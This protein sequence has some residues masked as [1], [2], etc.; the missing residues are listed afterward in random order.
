MAKRSRAVGSPPA[1]VVMIH[2]IRTYGQWQKTLGDALAAV[3]YPHLTHDYG[4]FGLHR[5]AWPAARSNRVEAFYDWYGEKRDLHLAKNKGPFRPNIVAHSMGTY[6]V[7]RAMEKFSDMHFGKIV[8]CGAILPRN[9]NWPL[10]IARDQVDEVLNDYGVDDIWA[11]FARLLARDAGSSGAKGF[12]L[13]RP[14]VRQRRFEKFRHSDYFRKSHYDQWIGYFQEKGLPLRTL[15]TSNLPSH[16]TWK[17]LSTQTRAIDR[18]VYEELD[19][20]SDV[21]LP[22]GLSAKWL[23]VNPDIYTLLVDLSE[24]VR[25]YVN[26]M[27]LKPEAFRLAME[28]KL[29]EAHIQP[30]HV[31]PYSDDMEVDIYLMSIAVDPDFRLAN[32]G[33]DQPA[34]HKLWYGL[35]EHLGALAQ[36]RRIF[37]RSMGAIVWSTE[38][39]TLCDQLGMREVAKDRFG[40]PIVR[41]DFKGP[42]APRKPTRLVRDLFRKYAQLGWP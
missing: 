31:Q 35:S 33:P 37:V 19:H 28:D 23:A 30:E 32:Q 29:R 21:A 11:R 41:L 34:F 6:I 15:R 1:A 8:F 17:E 13:G 18:R 40:H 2:G 3:P 5:F 38:G 12:T 36:E 22:K 25:G 14:L 16:L 26:A 20:Y 24:T 42:D 27:P 4:R 9:F 39:Q 7:G 10:L